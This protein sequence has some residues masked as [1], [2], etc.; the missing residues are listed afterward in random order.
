MCGLFG[1]FSST[2]PLDLASIDHL[3]SL[4]VSQ[5]VRGEDAFGMAYTEG[6]GKM[7]S[8]KQAGSVK[9]H[10]TI[11]HDAVDSVAVIGHTRYATHGSATQNGNNHPHRFTYRGETCYLCHNG[12]IG[13]YRQIATKHGLNLSTECDSEVIARFL[14]DGNGNLLTRLKN[15]V[16]EV[17]TYAPFA[18][19]ILTPHSLIIARRGNPLFWCQDST[20]TWFAST[21]TALH[22][23][24]FA[25]PMNSAF[26]FN[27]KSGDIKSCKLAKKTASTQWFLGSNTFG[28]GGMV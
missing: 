15:F 4:G 12:V 10:S 26:E 28:L 14:E 19:S 21:V 16:E 8:Y 20:G 7:F 3:V 2:S 25:L 6:D 11:L 24:V 1:F 5:S 22:S 23:K 27:L 17:E 18:A 13:N 9:T